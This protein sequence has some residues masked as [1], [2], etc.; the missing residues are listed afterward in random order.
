MA[1][2][3]NYSYSPDDLLQPVYCIVCRQ[4]IP[5]DISNAGKGICPDCVEIAKAVA[6]A[7]AT[8]QAQSHM[9][10]ENETK[11]VCD[12]STDTIEVEL[13][14]QN[15]TTEVKYYKFD[16]LVRAYVALTILISLG[17]MYQGLKYSEK[18]RQIEIQSETVH[19]VCEY[20]GKTWDRERR[21]KKPLQYQLSRCNATESGL[22]SLVD[23]DSE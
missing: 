22:H 6:A 4:H 7:T 9:Q 8:T 17:F 14:S 13:E 3:P 5:K 11:M 23:R 19:W 18:R 15:D 20:C 10:T 12:Q 16:W 1:Q 21:L 2:N